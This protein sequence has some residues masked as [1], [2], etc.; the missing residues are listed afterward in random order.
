MAKKIRRAPLPSFVDSLRLAQNSDVCVGA[1]FADVYNNRRE[2]RTPTSGQSR[3]GTPVECDIYLIIKEVDMD[4]RGGKHNGGPWYY[5][6]DAGITPFPTTTH[7]G[8]LKHDKDIKLWDFL[9]IPAVGPH[10]VKTWDIDTLVGTTVYYVS[11]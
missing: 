10:K 2:R 6:N 11:G 4:E 3:P 8:L 5:R 7:W 1:I 9:V